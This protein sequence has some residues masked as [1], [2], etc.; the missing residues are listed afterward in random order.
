MKAVNHAAK[1]P[2]TELTTAEL[3]EQNF[4]DLR[5]MSHFYGSWDDLRKII[6][7]LEDQDNERAFDRASEPYPSDFAGFADNQ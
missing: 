7:K 6:A 1:K 5:E 4:F 3:E 2:F